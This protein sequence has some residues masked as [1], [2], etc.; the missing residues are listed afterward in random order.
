MTV[1]A[2]KTQKLETCCWLP[3]AGCGECYRDIGL[4]CVLLLVWALHGVN[5]DSGHI[6]GQVSPR[7]PRPA[8]HTQPEHG[9]SVEK[10]LGQ[11]DEV[12]HT[13]AKL[14]ALL[15]ISLW[16][17]VFVVLGCNLPL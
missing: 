11:S 12:Q 1:F 6:P 3:P 5:T 4:L 15:F 7:P 8:H 16:L 9:S 14:A 2:Q 17:A 13:T 10:S